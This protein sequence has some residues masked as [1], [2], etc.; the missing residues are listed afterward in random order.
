MNNIKILTYL[1][2]IFAFLTM[3]CNGWDTEQDSEDTD[4]SDERRFIARKLIRELFN[5]RGALGVC[6]TPGYHYD[7]YCSSRGSGACGKS[8]NFGCVRDNDNSHSCGCDNICTLPSCPK[9]PNCLVK[10]S[11]CS[12]SADCCSYGCNAPPYP[13]VTPTCL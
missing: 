7:S 10:G 8:Y 4:L 12:R 1:L 11:K 2:L 5:K 13:G 6:S 9:R 3:H